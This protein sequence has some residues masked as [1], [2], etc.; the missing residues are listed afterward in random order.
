LLKLLLL[1]LDPGLGQLGDVIPDSKLQTGL[2]EGGGGCVLR[3][4]GAGV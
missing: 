4:Q 1:T 3:E 2:F